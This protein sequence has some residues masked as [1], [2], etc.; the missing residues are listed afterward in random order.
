MRHKKQRP[1]L[2]GR[3]DQSRNA[4]SSREQKPNTVPLALLAKLYGKARDDGDRR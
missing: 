1:R 4:G 2:G 3:H